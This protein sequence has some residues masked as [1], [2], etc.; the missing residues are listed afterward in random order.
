MG[1]NHFPGQ[2]S[3]VFSIG[4]WHYFLIDRMSLLQIFCSQYQICLMVSGAWSVWPPCL[5]T[6]SHV[7]MPAPHTVSSCLNLQ[8]S[9]SSLWLLFCIIQW[10][11]TVIVSF[12]VSLQCRSFLIWGCL[13]TLLFDWS[14]CDSMSSYW[15]D[16]ALLNSIH[17]ASW[18]DRL[19]LLQN[20]ILIMRV[21][22]EGS[23]CV[24]TQTPA[25]QHAHICCAMIS[26]VVSSWFVTGEWINVIS[27]MKST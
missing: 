15:A 18:W 13:C 17:I 1:G 9:Q 26:L 24:S 6:H 16:D 14:L 21:P 7:T 5:L 25:C 27:W 8:T 22:R 10:R 2:A 11:V 4:Q 3:F 23:F 20:R 12:W 19:F